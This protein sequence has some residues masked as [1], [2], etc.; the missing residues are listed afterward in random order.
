MRRLS[1]SSPNAAPAGFGLVELMV[2]LMLGLLLIGAV[3][4]VLLGQG[5]SQR[6][7]QALSAVQT[8]ARFVLYILERDL[9]RAGYSGCLNPVTTAPSVA[10]ARPYGDLN[11]LATAT[12]VDGWRD[13]AQAVAK[14]RDAN[15]PASANSASG[16]LRVSYVR[17]PAVRV[18][19]RAD[20]ARDALQISGNPAGWEAGDHLLVTDCRV[21]DLFTAT[22]VNSTLIAHA[23]N[24]GDGERRNAQAALAKRFGD[25]AR[26]FEPYGVIYYIRDS[27]EGS[28]R[29]P[30]LY[31]RRV[32]PE[33]RNSRALVK[34]ISHLRLRYGVDT[35]G[36][37]GPE[38]YLD[39]GAVADWSTIVAVR[40]GFV[41]ESPRPVGSDMGM[42]LR[43]FGSELNGLPEDGHLRRVFT[44]T[45]AL[46]NR[47]P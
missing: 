41:A 46:R 6:V 16:V 30:T 15:I 2:A 19:A 26:V 44:T 23:V 25:D 7:S 24:G 43:L 34:G 4:H 3:M 8:R 20:G 40:V 31:R 36:D 13:I 38:Q 45:V 5:A 11:I 39:A 42:T 14:P 9:R 35:G 12:S 33:V 1:R 10:G 18:V 22:N 29:A 21:A 28:R 27:G 17:D 47:L 37:A 32:V